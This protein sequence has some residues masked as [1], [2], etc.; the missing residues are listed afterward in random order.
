MV[1]EL[2][3]TQILSYFYYIFIMHYTHIKEYTIPYL[4]HLTLGA[5]ADPVG[6]HLNGPI[7]AVFSQQLPTSVG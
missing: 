1:R 7:E 2:N 4:L 6:L 3:D 5:G